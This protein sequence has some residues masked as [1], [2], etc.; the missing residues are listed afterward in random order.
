VLS[1]AQMTEFKKLMIDGPDPEI[2][3]SEH[4]KEISCRAADGD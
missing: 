1:E 2:A 4:L 3:M